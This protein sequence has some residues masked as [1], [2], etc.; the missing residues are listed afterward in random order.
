MLELLS[1]HH[2]Q[3]KLG[4]G[5]KTFKRQILKCMHE[6]IVRDDINVVSNR[7]YAKR[8]RLASFWSCKAGA[9]SAASPQASA[10]LFK[11]MQMQVQPHPKAEH[12]LVYTGFLDSLRATDN[13]KDT[14]K[15]LTQAEKLDT[16]FST[17]SVHEGPRG[18]MHQEQMWKHSR[19]LD[20]D[21]RE[22]KSSGIH[23]WRKELEL[24]KD[25]TEEEGQAPQYCTLNGY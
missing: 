18:H 13:C 8:L 6:H 7:S 22:R 19:S 15:W 1:L 11:G 21:G 25:G 3:L 9:R 24:S 14:E 20:Q 4:I 5:N 10:L 17:R 2:T 16:L 23:S 12:P